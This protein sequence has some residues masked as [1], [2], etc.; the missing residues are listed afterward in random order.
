MKTILKQVTGS[1]WIVT[2]TNGYTNKCIL[3]TSMFFFLFLLLDRKAKM[4]T[5]GT[6]LMF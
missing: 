5:F 6:T 1:M 4:H 3:W 2:G